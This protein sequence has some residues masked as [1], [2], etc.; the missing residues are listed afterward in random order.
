MSRNQKTRS[1]A[2]KPGRSGGGI[3]IGIFIGLVLGALIAAGAAYYF[4]RANPFQAA[5]ATPRIPAGEQPPVVLPGKPGDRPVARQD[6]QFYKI[7]PQGETPATAQ[8]AQPATQ[9]PAQQPAAV[10]EQ[11]YLQVGA[12]EDPAEADN[13]KARLAL[14]GIDAS[15]QRGQTGDGRVVHRVRIG[16]FAKPDDMA[17]MRSRLAEGGFDATVVKARP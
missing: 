12:F 16:P 14:S 13:L 10:V 9:V 6:F 11:L 4:T 17:P 1:S 2:R 5:P 3:I 8:P 15:A 7:L